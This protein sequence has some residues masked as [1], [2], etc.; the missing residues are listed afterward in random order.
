[1]KEHSLFTADQLAGSFAL[2][3][4]TI[5]D[6]ARMGLLHPITTSEGVF[7]ASKDYTRLQVIVKGRRLG[8]TLGEI[9]LL[10]EGAKRPSMG[11]AI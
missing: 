8:F 2:S 4:A 11:D 10:I 7:F 9:K 6:Y 5:N 3:V 1:M